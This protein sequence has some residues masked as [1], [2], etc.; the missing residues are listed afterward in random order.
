MNHWVAN[1]TYSEKFLMIIKLQNGPKCSFEFA[2]ILKKN[3]I[4]LLDNQKQLPS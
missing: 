1:N 3:W 4:E 2:P